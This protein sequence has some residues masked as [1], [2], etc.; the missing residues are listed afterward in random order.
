MMSSRA[1][2]WLAAIVSLAGLPAFA[3]PPQTPPAANAATVNGEPISEATL[4][5]ALERIPLSRRAEARTEILGYLIDNLLIDQYLRQ[6]KLQ[7]DPKQVET[8]VQQIRDDIK[9]SGQEFDKVMEKL[10]LSEAEI[11]AEV[12]ADLRW[13]VFSSGHAAEPALRELFTRE[14]EMFDGTQV[15][16]RHILLT[17]PASDPRAVEQ[18][19]ADL[20][21]IKAQI[22]RQVADG[23]AKLPASADNLARERERQQLL[24][25]AFSARAHEKSACPSK[26][27]G[28][29]VS[30]FPRGGSMVEPFARAAFAL[31][32]YEMSDVVQTPFG[33]HLILAID[34]KPGKSAQFEEVMEEVKEVFRSRLREEVAR[35]LRP[36]ARI[37]ITP[38]T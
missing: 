22:E 23:L 24:D 38:A 33:Y 16:A 27:H 8:R 37:V 10:H 34:R 31:K 11:R 2:F 13:E 19:K 25:D 20:K 29:D 9:K 7:V 21:A 36:A 4:A 30:W 12:V 26:E 32:A 3:Q 35:R 18:A 1:R 28:G 5:R 17:P 14:P 6:I 15:R